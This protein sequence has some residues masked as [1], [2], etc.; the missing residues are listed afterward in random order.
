MKTYI[1][2][3]KGLEIIVPHGRVSY[4]NYNPQELIAFTKTNEVVPILNK[5]NL[6]SNGISNSFELVN[7]EACKWVR[8]NPNLIE[9]I[10]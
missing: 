2:K 9:Y 8:I 5:V 10:G 6:V 3:V 1:K 4:V 7:F